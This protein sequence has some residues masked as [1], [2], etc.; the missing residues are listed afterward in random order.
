[1]RFV[2]QAAESAKINTIVSEEVK[3]MNDSDLIEYTWNRQG[4]TIN[5]DI[6]L[7][8]NNSLFYSEVVQPPKRTRRPAATGRAPP[9]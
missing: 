2:Q 4:E 6:T 5:I 8:T 1:M 9:G 7:R 3:E